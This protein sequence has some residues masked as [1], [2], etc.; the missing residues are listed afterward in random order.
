MQRNEMFKVTE[1]KDIFLEKHML[2]T[3][4]VLARYISQ[5]FELRS[6]TPLYLVYLWKS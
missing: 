4:H 3:S 1:K 5:P 6:H 2:L